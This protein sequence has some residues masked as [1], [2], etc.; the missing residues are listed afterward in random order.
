M[1]SKIICFHLSPLHSLFS[2]TELRQL[3]GFQKE[4]CE[5]M[6]LPQ[7]LSLIIMGLTDLSLAMS[8]NCCFILR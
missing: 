4:Q 1:H 6:I 3:T 8:L 5:P 2:I 7:I